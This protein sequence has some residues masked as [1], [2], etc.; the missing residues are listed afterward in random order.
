MSPKRARSLANPALNETV[1]YEVIRNWMRKE[2]IHARLGP[3]LVAEGGTI[4]PSMMIR[5]AGLL[6][7][8]IEAGC[9]NGV[10]FPSRLEAAVKR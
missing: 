9:K 1:Y 3:H 10:V 6:Q 5:A 7:G 4:Q 2:S 8:F